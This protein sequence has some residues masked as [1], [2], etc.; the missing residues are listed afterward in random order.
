[1]RVLIQRIKRASVKVD[2][3]NAAETGKGLLIFV[4]V[5]RDDDMEDIERMVKKVINLRVFEDENGKMN[6]NIKQVKG[7]ILSVSQF[8]LYADTRKGNRPGFDQAADPGLAKGHWKRFNNLL[9]ENNVNVREGIFGARMEVELI[10]DGP[11]T[12]WLDS[13]NP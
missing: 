6:L 3:N 12:I 8:T 7:E 2:G 13:K 4:G 11:V 1:M 10:N 5:G 9:R